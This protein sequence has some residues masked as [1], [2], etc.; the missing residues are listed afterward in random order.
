MANKVGIIVQRY[1][2]EINGGA[3]YHARLIAE[4]LSA[5]IEIEV[6]TSTAL[7]YVTWK[8]HYK[9]G[10]EL[11]NGIKTN[12][13]KTN[14][15][16]N[17]EVFGELQRKIYED[18][19]IFKDELEWLEEE[20]PFL[21]E[22]LE[23]IKK[24]ENEFDF[25]I[26]FSFRYYHSFY[27]INVVSDKGILVPTAE[28]DEVLYLRLFKNF[29]KFPKAII[30]NSVEEKEIIEKVSD[31]REILSDIV[32]VGSE[33]PELFTPES[34]REKFEIKGDY[35]VYIGR[36][37]ENKGVPQ[38]LSFYM[39]LLK[40]KEIDLTL[41]LMGKSV[42]TIPEHNNIKYIGFVSDKEKFDG[43]YGAKFLIIPSQYESL[44]MVSLEAW[45]IGKPVIANGRTEV[46]HGQ[47]R[48]SNAGLWYYNYDEFKEIILLLSKNEELR[49]KMGING[50]NFFKKNYSW[51]VIVD[52]YLNIFKKLKENEN[53]FKKNKKN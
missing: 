53:L 25:F 38:L 6:F 39:K 46:L 9:E 48:R 22:M 27:G 26:F 52:K 10:L 8:H 28:H 3:E 50:V 41:V 44:S 5:F 51:N 32:G 14:K 36:L 35:F 1:G 23:D 7:D 47:C 13:Y 37:D 18:E 2:N 42:I 40:E 11:I 15:E 20:G 24:R 49:K 45:A 16:R 29:F 21:P 19:H 12:R 34:F 43:L 4:K 31:N 30:Y 33:I 17:P